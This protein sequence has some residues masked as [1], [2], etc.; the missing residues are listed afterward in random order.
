MRGIAKEIFKSLGGGEN[1]LRWERASFQP[2][3]ASE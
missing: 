1:F 3:R 2:P